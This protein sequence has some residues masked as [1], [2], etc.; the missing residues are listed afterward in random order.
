M[1]KRHPIEQL[2]DI[3]LK[4][5]TKAGSYADG[6]G[7]YFKVDPSGSKSWVFRY[8]LD[9]RR[10]SMGLGG[11]PTISLAEAR[12]ARDYWRKILKGSSIIAPRDPLEVKQ[13]L[14]ATHK[15]GKRKFIT[16]D[17]IS[18]KYIAANRPS[19]SNPKHAQQWENSLRTYASPVIGKLHIAEIDTDDVLKVLEPLWTT[20]TETATRLRGRIEKV[21]D[22]ARARKLRTAENPA[23][24]RG[25]L[26]ALLAKP[27]KVATVENFSSLPY[28]QIGAFMSA[29][30]TRQGT[31]ALAL[32]FLILTNT[33]SGDVMESDWSE[34]DLHGKQWTIPA[35]RLKTRKEHIVPLSDR[36]I[37]IL[38][39][40]AKEHDEGLIF[41]GPRG[42]QLSNIAMAQVIKRMNG[43]SPRWLSSDGR[44]IVPHGFR[45]T[46]R[47]WAGEA[48]A[49]PRDLIEFA[50]A[51][52]LKDK[53]EA[54]Y[55]RSTLPE[56]RR[57]LMKDWAKRLSEA[58]QQAPNVVSIKSAARVIES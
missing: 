28:Q 20:K 21:I 29:L 19:W 44:P 15:K 12:E 6:R 10:R 50:M 38:N 51:H 14:E 46:F 52:Q 43:D 18:A 55:H 9:G 58:D 57:P 24:W 30:R 42:G 48:T 22:Y 34:I 4:R 49:Y 53:A 13:E 54:S 26:D 7:L 1:A 3:Q 31:A 11:Y 2:R 45:A 5:T 25:H 27:S 33:R 41:R 23:R 17:E 47:T 16:F 36:A 39:I 40:K 32:E 8:M 56:K 37:E 35:H